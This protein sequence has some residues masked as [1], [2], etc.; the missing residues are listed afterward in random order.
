MFERNLM[1]EGLKLEHD[2]V[3]IC[4]DFWEANSGL[5]R[6]TIVTC[7][8]QLYYIIVEPNRSE[9]KQ[10]N[11]NVSVYKYISSICSIS[12]CQHLPTYKILPYRATNQ[13]IL[14]RSM[15]RGKFLHDMQK[16]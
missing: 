4:E 5:I 12:V 9:T 15:H 1:D 14:S 7:A 13:Y 3:S 11:F 6:N 8:K 2:S 10:D 16:F